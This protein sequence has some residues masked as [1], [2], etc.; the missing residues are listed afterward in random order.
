MTNKYELLEFNNI[1]VIFAMSKLQVTFTDIP[2]ISAISEFKKYH[3]DSMAYSYLNCG[4][5]VLHP[6]IELK[7]IEL[8]DEIMSH[9]R[10][11]IREMVNIKPRKKSVR[12][13]IDS[14]FARWYFSQFIHDKCERNY[15]IP[16]N[17]TNYNTIYEDVEY[18]SG[19]PLSPRNIIKLDDALNLTE[20][21]NEAV[22]EVEA[23]IESE[24]YH[25]IP[26]E[27][28]KEFVER[29]VKLTL[30]MNG[31][32][33]PE[34]IRSVYLPLSTYESLREAYN[35]FSSV[36]T[37]LDTLIW[38]LV[39]RY[40]S[41]NIYNLQLAIHPSLYKKLQDELGVQFEMFASGINKFFKHYCSLFQDI[42]INFG[43]RGS[44]FG[45][46]PI[47]GFY[48][49]N[50]PFDTFI[51]NH[52]LDRLLESLENS[53][54][55]LGFFLTIPIWDKESLFKLK[56][57]TRKR[58]YIPKHITPFPAVKK[59]HA[60]KYLKYHQMFHQDD[61]RYYD[62]NTKRT[63]YVANTHVFILGNDKITINAATV[64]SI[65]YRF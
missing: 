63:K 29:S 17:A 45:F 39:A 42:E 47:K 34:K 33:I 21:C 14:M 32:I 38:I 55:P 3:T 22:E 60:S 44:F 40:I 46:V 64:D 49:V 65:L 16:Y 37:S 27:I 48:S 6:Q 51:I 58:V 43:S 15:Y 28:N 24:E 1:P 62:Y 56:H 54:E 5:Y 13:I 41:L 25:H 7:S 59:I 9:F 57:Q 36:Y 10:R 8:L 4:S 26:Y 53:T 61:F 30:D 35:E 19:K 2:V 23:F 52:T 31:V 50:P 20:L 11:V 18:Q 12:R